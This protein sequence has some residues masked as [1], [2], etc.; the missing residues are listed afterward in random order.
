MGVALTGAAAWA[1]EPTEPFLFQVRSLDAA[2]TLTRAGNG[3]SLRQ[4]L[5]FLP[6]FN[7]APESWLH[8]QR[9]KLKPGFL[10]PLLDQVAKV[11]AEGKR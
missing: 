2:T 8:K 6:P 3:A 5:E 11:W 1:S 7:S 4:G 9:E 10:Q